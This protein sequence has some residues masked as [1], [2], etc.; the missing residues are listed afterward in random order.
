[1][2]LLR[3]QVGLGKE[4]RKEEK[5]KLDKATKAKA[6]HYLPCGGHHDSIVVHNTCIVTTT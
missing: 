4:N 3:P 1:M 2:E 6:T 5:R